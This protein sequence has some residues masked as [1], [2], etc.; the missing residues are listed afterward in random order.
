MKR[1]VPLSPRQLSVIKSKAALSMS[2]VLATSSIAPTIALANTPTSNDEII[3][4]VPEDVNFDDDINV[5]HAITFTLS[6]ELLAETNTAVNSAELTYTDVQHL[7]T[8]GS[9]DIDAFEALGL[10]FDTINTAGTPDVTAS[11]GVLF[12]DGIPETVNSGQTVGTGNSTDFLKMSDIK[13]WY[14]GYTLDVTGRNSSFE[15]IEINDS[16]SSLID[17]LTLGDT[18]SAGGNATFSINFSGTFGAGTGDIGGANFAGNISMDIPIVGS[19]DDS[20]LSFTDTDADTTNE[21]TYTGSSLNMDTDPKFELKVGSTPLIMGDTDDY[22]LDT[23]NSTLDDG[24]VGDNYKVAVKAADDSDWGTS[25]A[26][27][28]YKIVKFDISQSGNASFGFVNAT[29]TGVD[30]TTT[31]DHTGDEI[32]FEVA[33][34]LDETDGEG[35]LLLRVNLGTATDFSTVLVEGE[36]FDLSYENNTDIALAGDAKPPTVIATGKNNYTGELKLNF[37]ISIDSDEIKKTDNY[38]AYFTAIGANGKAYFDYTGSN[39]EPAVEVTFNG[40]TLVEGT[41]YEVIYRQYDSGTYKYVVGAEKSG[42]AEASIYF[43]G[44]YAPVNTEFLDDLTSK[45]DWRAD[46]SDTSDA[47]AMKLEAEK[48]VYFP[49]DLEYEIEGDFSSTVVNTINDDGNI[50]TSFPYVKTGLKPDVKVTYNGAEVGSAY[51]T[52][53]NPSSYAV[54]SASMVVNGRTSNGWSGSRTVYY[55]ITTHN[56]ES[57]EAKVVFY[58]GADELDPAAATGG[59]PELK[60]NYGNAVTFEDQSDY[61]YKVYDN[62]GNLLEVGTDYEVLY[63]GN[64]AIGSSK[65]RIGG[66]G[67]YSGTIDADF[68]I[69]ADTSN[70]NFTIEPIE[71]QKWTGDAVE[72]DIVVKAGSVTLKKDIDYVLGTTVTPGDASTVDA[73]DTGY[74]LNTNAG[75]NTASVKIS[76]IGNYTGMTLDTTD[77]DYIGNFSILYDIDNF[78]FVDDAGVS[79][80]KFTGADLSDDLDIDAYTIKANN[81][82]DDLISGGSANPPSSLFSVALK[83]GD[84]GKDVGSFNMVFSVKDTSK[85]LFLDNGKD[86]DEVESFTYNIGAVTLTADLTIALSDSNGALTTGS[87][88]KYT[89]SEVKP[90]II[91]AASAVATGS[92]YTGLDSTYTLTEDVD[93]TV[94]YNGNTDVTGSDPIVVT[95]TGKGNFSG[96]DA[97][98]NT[99]KIVADPDLLK[100]SIQAIPKQ[101]YIGVALTPALTVKA[102]GITLAEDVDYEIVDDTTDW[103][104]NDKA[105]WAKVTIGG[106]AGTGYAGGTDSQD[107]QIW[108]QLNQATLSLTDSTG[109]AFGT[110]VPYQ[111]G[112]AVEPKVVLKFDNAANNAIASGAEV[113]LDEDWYDVV[114]ANN[115][116]VGMASVTAT[117]KS[118]AYYEGT[119][120]DLFSITKADFGDLNAGHYFEGDATKTG[121]E[122]FVVK[123]LSDSSN[124]ETLSKTY[125]GSEIEFDNIQ[126]VQTLIDGNSYTLVK[127]TDYTVKYAN[128]KDVSDSA[129]TVTITGKGGYSGTITQKFEIEAMSGALKAS[130]VDNIP[131]QTYT[132]AE[133]KPTV[134]VTFNGKTLVE[135]TNDSSDDNYGDYH[136]EYDDNK[137]PGTAKVT[138]IPHSPYGDPT[139]DEVEKTFQIEGDLSGDN[140]KVNISKDEVEYTGSAITGT[141]AADLTA[142]IDL[143]ALKNLGNITITLEND[144]A[145]P[146]TLNTEYYNL[147]FSS[148]TNVGTGTIS[149]TPVGSKGFIGSN[150]AEFE[151]TRKSLITSTDGVNA[152][153]VLDADVNAT[154][155]LVNFGGVYDQEYNGSEIKPNISVSGTSGLLVENTDYTVK[156]ENNTNIGKATITVE[157]KGNYTGTITK[158]FNI[159]TPSDLV[160]AGFTV[161]DI[162]DVAYTGKDVT[163]N[164]VVYSGD[165]K[166]TQG[167]DY[168]L[169]YVDPDDDTEISDLITPSTSVDVWVVG[170]NDYVD[171]DSKKAEFK[172]IA[173]LSI[174]SYVTTTF[175]S[176]AVTYSGEAVTKDNSA[177]GLELVL[178]ADDTPLVGITSD[179]TPDSTTD[180]IITYAENNTN[181]GTVRWTIEGTGAYKGTKTISFT[182]KQKALDSNENLVFVGDK[183][184]GTSNTWE[185]DGTASHGYTGGAI[186][187]DVK[188]GSS[189][190]DTA[191]SGT[192]LIKDTDYTVSYSNNTNANSEAKI[193]IVGK[194]N[195]SGSVSGAFTVDDSSSSNLTFQLKDNDTSISNQTYSNRALTPTIDIYNNAGVKLTNKTHYTLSYDEYDEDGELVGSDSAITPGPAAMIVTGEG[196][197]YDH[198]IAGADASND[199]RLL[200]PFNIVAPLTSSYLTYPTIEI[201]YS[202]DDAKNNTLETLL[203]NDFDI[204]LADKSTSI[205]ETPAVLVD[206][207]DASSGGVGD[208]TDY[209]DYFGFEFNTTGDGGADTIGTYNVKISPIVADNPY[210]TGTKTL[211]YKVVAYDISAVDATTEESVMDVSIT[212]VDFDKVMYTGS[213]ITFDT[214]AI[215]VKDGNEN[216]L[217]YNID[218]TVSYS[219]NTNTGTATMNII[220]KGNYTGTYKQEF[221]IVSPAEI[222]DVDFDLSFYTGMSLSNQTYSG[223]ALSPTLTVYYQTGGGDDLKWTTLRSGTDYKFEYVVDGNKG[224]ES[225][226]ITYDDTA[227]AN[228]TAIEDLAGNKI[229]NPIYPGYYKL[230]AKGIDEGNYGDATAVA[231][232]FKVVTSLTNS[233][234]NYTMTATSYTYT[235]SEIDIDLVD[236]SNGGEMG[237]I[238]SPTIAIRVAAGDTDANS[239]Y[240]TE[241]DVDVDC[242]SNE[243]VGIARLTVTPLDADGLYTGSKVLTY[244]IT[245][246]N[247]SEYITRG[248]NGTST[249]DDATHYYDSSDKEYKDDAIAAGKT[250]THIKNETPA[251]ITF[252][253]SDGTTEN[254]DK[255][256]TYNKGAITPSIKVVCDGITLAEGDDYTVSYS[257]NINLGTE[258][259]V[260]ITGKGNYTGS[261]TDTFEIEAST[262][263]D[264]QTMNFKGEIQATISNQTYTGNS[265]KP[266]VAAYNDNGNGDALISGTD[267][268]IT[269]KSYA[270]AGATTADAMV[271]DTYPTNPGK[272]QMV[273]TGKDAYEEDADNGPN[274]LTADFY[275]VAPLSSS[276]ITNDFVTGTTVPFKG[277]AYT[278]TD[279]PITLT[280][281]DN[282]VI[283]TE[284]TIST[285]T[286]VTADTA[287]IIAEFTN[288]TAAGTARVTLSA[289]PAGT[290]NTVPLFSGTKTFTFTIS[291]AVMNTSNFDIKAKNKDATDSEYKDL[292]GFKAN[293]TG[294][295]VTPDFQITDT[296]R[297]YI[298]VLNTDYT[299][300]YVNNTNVGDATIVINGRGSYSGALS[301]NTFTIAVSDDIATEAVVKFNN[302]AIDDNAFDEGVTPVANQTLA[303]SSST[304][305]VTAS[306]P[307][308]A[309]KVATSSGANEVTLRETTNYTIAYSGNGTPG[310]ATATFTGEGNYA[311]ILNDDNG[312]N[313]VTWNVLGNLSTLAT[314]VGTVDTRYYA[315]KTDT[316]GVTMTTHLIDFAD[317]DAFKGLVTFTGLK[318]DGTADTPSTLV[319]DTDY[320]VTYSGATTGGIGTVTATFTG[321]N[322]QTNEDDDEN[323]YYTGSTRATYS[324]V[325]NDITAES[326]G[327]WTSRNML[328]PTDSTKKTPISGGE[329]AYPTTSAS[330]TYTGSAIKPTLELVYKNEDGKPITL[331]E[332]TDYT[333]AYSNNTNVGTATMTV[334]GRTGF[335]GSFKVDFAITPITSGV[336]TSGSAYAITNPKV[337]SSG[338]GVSVTPVVYGL[339]NDRWTRLTANTHY[340]VEYAQDGKTVELS[341]IVADKEVTVH[342][343]GAGIYNSDKLTTGNYDKTTFTPYE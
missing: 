197:M 39:V 54:G 34:T 20:N 156:Y 67:N 53:A 130:D 107:F 227:S 176:S 178:K 68:D 100:N 69:V 329:A 189:S 308:I 27:A 169:V 248:T 270:T 324:I 212:G 250:A 239:I 217:V 215:T 114:Y 153:G 86:L 340:T 142:D 282:T 6:K 261:F 46:V 164:V 180:Y 37:N 290:T 310:K 183:T 265:I 205:F 203:E 278:I 91:S 137:D 303:Y 41:D 289:A 60:F 80:F 154:G 333:I 57:N 76:G 331:V 70:F 307:S 266:T 15:V 52:K 337:N 306:K 48:D 129:P 167:I 40:D 335:T 97:V 56:F 35:K 87:S 132:G 276:A 269:Y 5:M 116:A 126:I 326:N 11:N 1:K 280:L 201:P 71:D 341:E 241:D 246:R 168:K 12:I 63:I 185:S 192:N 225:G 251:K 196:D 26:E 2:M 327:E 182:I 4:E 66:L 131:T 202:G 49:I 330:Y 143:A 3:F 247:I 108:G 124:G 220:G 61:T 338:A 78:T 243:N 254:N 128:N 105:G 36:D 75:E 88:Y 119:K 94:S 208:D 268:D 147:N 162:D 99:F 297:N 209:E 332:N 25:T 160:D 161:S 44:M 14:V 121:T 292:E 287:D 85:K 77:P 342:V 133:I 32:T 274:I 253:D 294:S 139:E 319:K 10:D 252:Y 152:D 299:V 84:S 200:V 195:Y 171:L 125:T 18:S 291:Q 174:A 213:A 59:T 226:S 170:I 281:K 138:I 22:V 314:S 206:D 234:L 315:G 191:G 93:Y 92:S 104:D 328:A 158:T 284:Y 216:P 165:D 113:T 321:R 157:G 146:I 322:D 198:L 257:N 194:G 24:S 309:V 260:Y 42:G 255:K 83:E 312:N 320:T 79:A 166:L 117:G 263:E 334:T 267:Y 207:H 258:A 29:G 325:A 305:T 272:Y 271:A 235:G 283:N 311:G 187:P 184:D 232:P 136:V 23:E 55:D 50:T 172:I 188:V 242:S 244:T 106:V 7:L 323:G 233:L 38:E 219:S 249:T 9:E 141:K 120:F 193:T 296:D 181:A 118:S 73:D 238:A 163:P 175:N 221:E 336:I 173:D 122:T 316:E 98:T 28:S 45:A 240:L 317:T 96:T 33:G 222:D 275:I 259:T 109:T 199:K 21:Y 204:F 81:T 16:N 90:S 264:F 43:K 277:E 111:G 229:D 134:V 179:A 135:G 47:A 210:Y 82:T 155:S 301:G 19:F 30:A 218:Y 300:T 223:R 304:K 236:L 8:D 245:Q 295:A 151:I 110:S 115:T 74:T 103:V 13:L 140:I 231:M 293:F 17:N 228:D 285:D 237:D 262:G 145:T 95:V 186:T 224:T 127:D 148:N 286:T 230:V 51:Y 279:K 58:K 112:K 298:L 102:A 150:S 302:H 101:Q 343:Y 123:G 144:G 31:E 211:Y 89:G 159:K 214:T 190:T 65:M 256:Y 273:I 72:P 288:N 339:V 318:D 177:L 313:V 62:D 64:T 149:V